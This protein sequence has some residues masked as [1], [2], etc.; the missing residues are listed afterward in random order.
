VGRKLTAFKND[1]ES[2]NQAPQC[3]TGIGIMEIKIV[4]ANTHR[5]RL[6][7][8]A[9]MS[10]NRTSSRRKIWA[11]SKSTQPT[12]RAGIFFDSEKNAKRYAKESGVLIAILRQ[13]KGNHTCDV[14]SHA[15]LLKLKSRSHPFILF[16]LHSSCLEVW[17]FLKY[18]RSS[19]FIFIFGQFYSH[20]CVNNRETWTHG[21]QPHEF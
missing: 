6:K 20:A 19:P 21:N 4:D 3:E 16:Q 15:V 18:E 12:A 14:P 1:A 5:K 7:W 8:L 17:L 2:R 9:G 10:S 11:N 13:V